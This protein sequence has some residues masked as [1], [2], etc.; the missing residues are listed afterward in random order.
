MF[1]KLS[2]AIGG[3][4]G[5]VVLATLSGTIHY[6][7]TFAGSSALPSR[8]IPAGPIPSL[9][10]APDVFSKA[11]A[12]EKPKAAVG[13]TVTSLISPHHLLAA[14]LIARAIW[15][16]SG[17]SYK[18]VIIM[19]PDHFN[20]SRRPFATTTRDI[21]TVFGPATNDRDATAALEAS[22]DLFEDSDLFAGEHGVQALLPFVRKIFPDARIVPIAIAVTSGKSDWD[23]AFE[24]LKPLVGPETL[25]VQ[26]T[27]F[28]HYLTPEVAQQRDQESLNLLARNQADDI[29]PLVQPDHLDSKAA[30]YIQ[31]RLSRLSDSH[32][33]VLANRNSAE[34]SPGAQRTT[35]YIV[36][37]Y[38]HGDAAAPTFADETTL[39]FGGDFFAGRWLTM[40]LAAEAM[41]AQVVEQV[42]HLTAGAPMILNLEGSIADE[43]PANLPQGLHAMDAGLALPLLRQLHV[44]G[45]SLANNHGFDLG[46][47][48]L[49][50]SIKVLKG[51]GIAPLENGRIVDLGPVRV[52]ALNYVG[53]GGQRK[54][55]PTVDANVMKR[56][57]KDPARPPVLAFVHWGRE[58]TTQAD[59]GERSIVQGLQ[60]CGIA[61]VIGA[62][63][64]Q[65]SP[66]VETTPGGETAYVYSLGNFLFD[67]H[68]PRGT[69]QLLEL[70]FFKQ[71]T[72]ASRL[73][74]LPNFFDQVTEPNPARTSAPPNDRPERSK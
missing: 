50:E 64:H 53:Q 69:G 23:R 55:D 59:A 45:A 26:S 6:G 52:V 54:S 43:V 31:M 28:S 10:S 4:A 62:H 13:M 7:T 36:A 12:E 74:P 22:A 51:A 56:I 5:Y 46:A 35:S 70:R 73:V 33:V 48:G 58:Y 65:A 49:S 68:S 38:I 57:C 19:S 42:T 61:I 29:L 37:A 2:P 67:Q 44:T 27:D 17:H 32:P 66:G 15:S 1:R 21:D 60:T 8:L 20:K 47:S 63:S 16:A 40:P 14:D 18:R 39:F 41:R 11:I 9:Y 25:V 3:L 34:Y 24:L 30:F 72:F 71:G